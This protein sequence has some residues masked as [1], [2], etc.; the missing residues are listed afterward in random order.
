MA[1]VLAANISIFVQDF[2][3]AL[4]LWLASVVRE[5]VPSGG[6]GVLVTLYIAVVRDGTER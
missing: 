5:E 4:L 2:L 3:V 1:L 6:I